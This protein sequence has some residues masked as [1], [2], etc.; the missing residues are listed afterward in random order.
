[1]SVPVLEKGKCRLLLCAFRLCFPFRRVP[2][3][4]CSDTWIG[5]FFSAWAAQS[6]IHLFLPMRQQQQML[7]AT[8]TKKSLNIYL[9]SFCLRMLLYYV[10]WWHCSGVFFCLLVL[11]LRASLTWTSLS[12]PVALMVD[13]F[14]VTPFSSPLQIISS[15]HTARTISRFLPSL[16]AFLFF[17]L[18]SFSK[19]QAQ[20]SSLPLLQWAPPPP[21]PSSWAKAKPREKH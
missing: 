3:Y 20:L 15:L 19:L 1:M 6:W 2:L 5:R 11:L 4:V 17:G 16:S 14:S 18:L 7:I 21:N 12:S 8:N 13:W 9:F 10:N